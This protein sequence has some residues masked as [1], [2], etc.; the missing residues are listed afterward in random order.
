M[1]NYKLIISYDGT[2][3]HG[4]QRQPKKRSIQGILEET[5]N[6]ITQKKITI[7]GA[8]RTDAGVHAQGQVATFKAIISLSEEELLQALNSLIPGD[9]KVI[10]LEKT[11]A[12]F[13]ARKMAKSKIYQ[14]RIFNSSDIPPFLHRYVLY[15]R[16]PLKVEMMKKA[17][18]LFVREADFTAFSSNRFLNPVRKVTSSRIEKKGREI[19]YT[20]EANGF[21]RYMVRTIVGTLLE[22]G[23]GKLNPENIEEILKKKRRS[24]A[25][26]TAPAKGLCLLKVIY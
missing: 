5:L 22:V 25:G 13:H 1:Q 15:W 17:A 8:G 4:W 20:I 12:N 3:Y 14:Y 23:K 6:K 10:S 2:D 16:S 11:E 18:L 24:Q 19:I 7:I 9:I 21:L 26:P